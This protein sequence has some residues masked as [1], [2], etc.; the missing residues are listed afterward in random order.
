MQVS[1]P[2]RGK[3]LYLLQ[4]RPHRLWCTP[5]L[6]FNVY[7]GSSPVLERTGREDY[8]LPPSN[9][10]VNNEY[11]RPSNLPAWRG[12]EWLPF[13]LL[14]FTASGLPCSGTIRLHKLFISSLHPVIQ[15]AICSDSSRFEYTKGHNRWQD[16]IN[17]VVRSSSKV[18]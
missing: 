15:Q 18:S 9:A 13:H 12:Q 11:L 4:Y 8:D 17:Y 7:R 6:L 3:S 14:C 2:G 5:S 16:S 1:G 10:E